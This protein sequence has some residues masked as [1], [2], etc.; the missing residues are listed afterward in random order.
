MKEVLAI[1]VFALFMAPMVGHASTV[2]L[3][4]DNISV[5]VGS[6]TGTGS[7]NNTFLL[8]QTIEKVIDAPSADAEEFH[9]QVTHIWY[10]FADPAD[11][12]ELI[13]DFGISYDI[14]ELHFWNYTG[15]DFDVDQVVFTFFDSIGDTIGTTTIFPALGSSP[16]ITAEDIPLISPLNTRKVTAFLTGTNGQVDFQNIGFT[17]TVSDPDL[18]P[19]ANV[20]PLPAGFYLMLAGLGG[21]ATLKR[22]SKN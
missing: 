1:S 8:G 6:N 3:N 21:I 14:T 20:I 15:E 11:G 17:A 12:L 22:R 7:S 16:G 18:D 19:N 10:T 2:Y 5:S 13:F 4:K 9:D